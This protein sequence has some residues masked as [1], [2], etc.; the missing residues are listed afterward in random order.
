MNDSASTIAAIKIGTRIVFRFKFLDPPILV[1]ILPA[2]NGVKSA[3]GRSLYPVTPILK[4][5]RHDACASDV[6]RQLRN[7]KNPS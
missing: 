4:L 6:F 3:A 7:I 1:Y 2:P 5:A